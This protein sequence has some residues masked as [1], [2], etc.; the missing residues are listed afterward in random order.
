MNNQKYLITI[1]NPVIKIKKKYAIIQ[2]QFQGKCKPK[3]L[4]TNK[5]ISNRLKQ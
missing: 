1:L 4:Y 5:N 2:K 3:K